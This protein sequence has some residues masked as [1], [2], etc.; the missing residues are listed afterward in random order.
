MP[1]PRLTAVGRVSRSC[2]R[3]APNVAS[4]RPEIRCVALDGGQ[5]DTH[6]AGHA[7]GGRSAH[8]KTANRLGKALMILGVHHDQLP[9]EASL[10]DEAYSPVDPVDGARH[11]VV[12]HWSILGCR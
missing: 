5:G 8:F 7:E 10:I 11:R 6:G 4:Q 2:F 3:S 12:L 1:Q 9:G